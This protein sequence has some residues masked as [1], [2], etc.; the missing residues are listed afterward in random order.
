VIEKGCNTP[1]AAKRKKERKKKG[2]AKDTTIGRRASAPGEL[3]YRFEVKRRPSVLNKLLGYPE[4]RQ[5]RRHG[6]DNYIHAGQRCC[7]HVEFERRDK[8]FKGHVHQAVWLE[9]LSPQIF[10]SFQIL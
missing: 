5:V 2:R 9:M 1:P 8:A 6:A 7:A 3:G 4:R 10:D